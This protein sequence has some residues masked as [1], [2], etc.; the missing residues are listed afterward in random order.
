METRKTAE[1]RA[2]KLGFP[3]SSVVT[4]K[5]ESFIAPR[6]VTSS[7]GKQQY[8]AMRA[9]G[10]DKSKASAIATAAEKKRKG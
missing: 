4:R 5:G 3:K 1:K 6:A 7:K 2:Q 10:M 9:Q 8:A